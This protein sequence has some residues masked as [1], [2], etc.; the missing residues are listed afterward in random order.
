MLI[1]WGESLSP[2][3]SIYMKSVSYKSPWD[4]TPSRNQGSNL[5]SASHKYTK[6]FEW[7]FLLLDSD[8]YKSTF[9]FEGA[10][11]LPHSHIC[12]E[13]LRFPPYMAGKAIT[14]GITWAYLDIYLYICMFVYLYICICICIIVFVLRAITLGIIRRSVQTLEHIAPLCPP[15]INDNHL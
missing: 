8:I 7:T 6:H 9:R 2:E 10:F 15:R 5:S 11:L 14:L 3:T 13:C 12:E 4:L 1:F